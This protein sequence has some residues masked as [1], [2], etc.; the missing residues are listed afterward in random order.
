MLSILQLAENCYPLFSQNLSP[1]NPNIPKQKIKK[2]WQIEKNPCV[3]FDYWS[4][5]KLWHNV[6]YKYI[7]EF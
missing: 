3:Y 7:F 4:E 1:Y 6:V 2:A 5:I